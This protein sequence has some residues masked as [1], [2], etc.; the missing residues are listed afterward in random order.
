MDRGLPPKTLSEI[1]IHIDRDRR[2]PYVVLSME[3]ASP[4]Q[5]KHKCGTYYSKIVARTWA[6]ALQAG[7]MIV[8]TSP[9][10]RTYGNACFTITVLPLSSSP[11][12]LPSQAG[13][14]TQEGQQR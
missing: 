6:R 11:G 1:L 12:P 4:T 14:D 3:H 2:N 9:T 13:G 7:D 10:Q 8:L 5:S